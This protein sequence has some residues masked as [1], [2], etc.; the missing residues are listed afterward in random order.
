MVRIWFI[1]YNK[2]NIS[3]SENAGNS[4]QLQ[5]FTVVDPFLL[6]ERFVV[7]QTGRTLSVR[8][9]RD[10]IKFLNTGTLRIRHSS[11]LTAQS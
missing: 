7:T 11:H 5:V 1:I 4:N 3:R 2:N 10:E 9:V 8:P 6:T